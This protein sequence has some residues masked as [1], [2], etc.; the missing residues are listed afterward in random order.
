MDSRCYQ[1]AERWRNKMSQSLTLI[2][3]NLRPR[4]YFLAERTG[5][6]NKG[7]YL[8]LR[9]EIMI[10]IFAVLLLGDLCPLTWCQCPGEMGM[11]KQFED[12]WN[13]DPSCQWHQIQ[14]SHHS[15]HVKIGAQGIR[16]INAVFAQVQ[17][18]GI[19]Y[20]LSNKTK[21][22]LRTGII[23]Y[24]SVHLLGVCWG[25]ESTNEHLLETQKFNTGIMSVSGKHYISCHAFSIHSVHLCL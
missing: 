7:P 18:I 16:V 13:Q 2:W 25:T 1:E 8:F 12:S 3:A 9:Q 5:S 15:L 14:E 4:T 6:Q 24:F 17:I 23:T 22:H 19:Y 10:I 11:P 21:A 20:L